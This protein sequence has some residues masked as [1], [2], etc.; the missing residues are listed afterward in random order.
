MA[1]KNKTTNEM[2]NTKTTKEYSSTQQLNLLSPVIIGRSC[3]DN[4]ALAGE[5]ASLTVMFLSSTHVSANQQN[6]MTVQC[7]C[8]TTVMFQ[9]H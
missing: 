9:C 2:K 6:I 1:I 3:E 5:V 8:L 4:L 7:E